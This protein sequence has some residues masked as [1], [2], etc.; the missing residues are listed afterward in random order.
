MIEIAATAPIKDSGSIRAVDDA[1]H[2]PLW[3]LPGRSRGVQPGPPRP[4]QLTRRPQT[5]PNREVLA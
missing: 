4:H 3:H 1:L 5:V 2:S